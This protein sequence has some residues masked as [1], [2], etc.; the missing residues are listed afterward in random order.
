MRSV[1]LQFPSGREL[2]NSYWGFLQ[3]GGL[4]LHEPGDLHEGDQL[5]VDVKIRS[6]KQSY[7]FGVH[8]V[9][10]AQGNGEGEKIFVAFDDGQD[11]EMMLNAA[12]ADTHEV[13]QRKHRRFPMTSAVTFRAVGAP[14]RAGQ[15]RLLNLSRGGC[16]VK[17][18]HAL[19]VGTRIAV[20]A[21]GFEL[22]GRVRW[23]TPAG[24]MGIEFV[25][26]ASDELFVRKTA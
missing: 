3:H 15:G 20:E 2:L 11:Q 8:V 13:P 19:S 24:E 10:R 1:H 12:W 5:A 7:K 21:G 6:L 26:P 16:R 18:N 22:H 9:R 25:Q 17:G 4:I 14:S 23:N